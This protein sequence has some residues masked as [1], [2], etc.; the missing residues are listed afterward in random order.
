MVLFAATGWSQQ[1]AATGLTGRLQSRSDGT[2]QH[3]VVHLHS[4]KVDLAAPVSSSG[5]Y[6]FRTVPSGS[7][8]LSLDWDGGHATYGQQVAL[9]NAQPAQIAVTGP[10]SL[11]LQFLAQ[12]MRT[13]G[14]DLGGQTVSAI[15]LNKRDFGQLLLLAAGTMTDAN[16]ATN[17]PK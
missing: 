14:E 8:T 1:P 6:Q 16:G 3:A 5:E 10:N 12:T 4:D 7:Y 2:L 11:S 13:G 17:A 15:P 9:P